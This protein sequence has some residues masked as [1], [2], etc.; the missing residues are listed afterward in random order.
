MASIF[1]VALALVSRREAHRVAK[2]FAEAD[3][4]HL[5]LHTRYVFEDDKTGFSLVSRF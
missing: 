1:V 3:L 2:Q 5:E 4:I